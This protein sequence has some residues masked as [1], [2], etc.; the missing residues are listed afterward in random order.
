MISYGKLRSNSED[1]SWIARAKAWGPDIQNWAE[2]FEA[3]RA[4]AYGC[5]EDDSDKEEKM[6]LPEEEVSSPSPETAPSPETSPPTGVWDEGEAA[7]DDADFDVDDEEEDENEAVDDEEY[8][9][10]RAAAE[11]EAKK[12][13]EEDEFRR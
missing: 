2:V 7:H 1:E 5:Y 3:A 4:K 13:Y 6:E 11:D 12:E 9:R 10:R 8:E